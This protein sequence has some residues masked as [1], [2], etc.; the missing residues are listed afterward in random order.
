M[1]LEKWHF[2]VFVG[3][4]SILVRQTNIIWMFLLA[5]EYS[6]HKIDTQ[7]KKVFQLSRYERTLLRSAKV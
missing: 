3:I 5:A 2:W 1:N 7:S 4:I 6:L